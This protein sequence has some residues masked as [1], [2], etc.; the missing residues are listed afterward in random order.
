MLCPLHAGGG[1]GAI[2]S[3]PGRVGKPEHLQNV[4]AGGFTRMQYGGYIT[5]T[6]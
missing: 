2:G 3:D 6:R 5:M 4:F 1:P